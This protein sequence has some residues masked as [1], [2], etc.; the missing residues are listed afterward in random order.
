LQDRA[1]SDRRARQEHNDRENKLE[2]R[3]K[4]MS[5]LMRGLIPKFPDDLTK[6]PDY[7]N[8]IQRLFTLY[9]VSN[10]LKITL[11]TPHFSEKARLLLITLPPNE[12]ESYE[13]FRDA[14]LREFKLT[15]EKY[16]EGF[17]RTD[18]IGGESYENLSTRLRS[19]LRFSKEK[20]V[21][22][23]KYPSERWLVFLVI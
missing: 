4:R 23:S 16:L 11:V 7:L 8:S 10:D 21:C 18:K 20:K 13:G 9:S 5:D 6:I 12:I 17:N 14:I 19:N 2:V 1:D 15:P 3:L 22:S